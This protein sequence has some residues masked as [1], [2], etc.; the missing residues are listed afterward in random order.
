ML[1]IQVFIF[2]KKNRTWFIAFRIETYVWIIEYCKYVI[3]ET[4]AR[5]CFLFAKKFFSKDLVFYFVVSSGK[6]KI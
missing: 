5:N 1:P 6:V 3:Y 4:I 2:F